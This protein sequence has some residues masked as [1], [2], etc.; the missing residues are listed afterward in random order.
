MVL[1]A[2]EVRRRMLS[3]IDDLPAEGIVITKHGE[4]MARLVPVKRK[5]KGRYVTGPLIP[6]KGPLGPLCPMEE[7][8]YDLLFD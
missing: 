1:N 2:T 6:G 3:L 4:P 8:N 7:N 5:A